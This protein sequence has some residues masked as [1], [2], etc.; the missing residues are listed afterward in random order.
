MEKKIIGFI[1]YNE[2]CQSYRQGV[3]IKRTFTYT[4]RVKRALRSS[5]TYVKSSSNL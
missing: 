1:R 2:G 5:Y 4:A 3:E